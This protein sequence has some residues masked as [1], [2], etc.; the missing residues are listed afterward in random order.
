MDEKTYNDEEVA[1]YINQHF[2][3]IKVD[4]DER[5]DVD[6]RLQEAAQ[7]ISGQAG[8]PLT[9][10]M[11]PEGEVIWAATYLPPRREMGLPGMVE[12]LEAVLKAYREERG[13]ISQFH[14]D[15][16]RELARW[17]APSS[18]GAEA[19]GSARCAGGAGVV[20]RRGVRR[21]RRGA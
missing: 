12:V 6:R 8:W 11:T 9:V 18:G 19:G 20:L 4:R 10:F 14:R 3:P 15:L 7:L 21:L 2:V 16:T 13:D 5:P 17:H 1:A